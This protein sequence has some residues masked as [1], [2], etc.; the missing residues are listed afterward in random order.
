MLKKKI[1][2]LLFLMSTFAI[3]GQKQ[4]FSFSVGVVNGKAGEYVYNPDTGQKISY[5]DWEIKNI[6]VFIGEYK[7]SYNNFEAGIKFKK[8]FSEISSG[9]MKD[10]D[11]YSQE[12]DKATEKDYGKPSAF[13]DN[14]NYVENLFS[15]DINTR[16][17]FNHNKYFKTGPVLGVRYD[18]FKFKDKGGY[19]YE[20]G[21][22]GECDVH[23]LGG[24]IGIIYRQKFLTPYIGYGMVHNYKKWTNRLEI[25]GCWYGKAKAHDRHL[26]RG[27]N[28]AKEKY[29]K[30]ENLSLEFESIYNLTNSVDIKLGLEFT[31]YFKNRKSTVDFISDGGE[32]TNGIKNLSGLKN[33][34][35]TISAGITY[36]F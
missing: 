22:D 12:D 35:Y 28:E 29:K 36:K 21:L 14:K 19:Q 5:L 9:R 16:Y 27:F 34:T 15:F 1:I 8:N 17:W 7:Y 6:P 13:S 32:K 20:Y 31:K 18:Y 25:K 3:A 23:Y 24:D 4:E 11:W 30:V 2:I 10:Y 33:M 26:A